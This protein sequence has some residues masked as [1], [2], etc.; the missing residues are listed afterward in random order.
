MPPSVPPPPQQ[1][2]QYGGAG[3]QQQQ[4]QQQFPGFQFPRQQPEEAQ[5]GFYAQVSTP[6][7]SLPE[8]A[9]CSGALSSRRKSAF[10]D[11]F[12]FARKIAFST[13]ILQRVGNGT[14]AL[15]VL[16]S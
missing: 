8:S 5:S 1:Y 13:A 7:L 12:Q 11:P 10:G 14:H 3:Q 4:Q 15:G 2:L 9:A 16:R 6:C